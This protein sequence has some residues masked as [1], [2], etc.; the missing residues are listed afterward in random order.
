M[1]RLS[2]NWLS[3]RTLSAFTH[4][5][6][7]DLV[8]TSVAQRMQQALS[9]HAEIEAGLQ[10]GIPFDQYVINMP[11]AREG[12]N[13]VLVNT[14]KE[15][16]SALHMGWILMDMEEP[17]DD[18]NER[19]EK[20]SETLDH[21]RKHRSALVGSSEFLSGYYLSFFKERNSGNTL[22]VPSTSIVGRV[23]L[24]LFLTLV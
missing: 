6:K 10:S 7:T 20:I 19:F 17:L 15:L 13:Q 9:I 8:G 3:K 11:L 18:P 23:P 22:F 14:D 12:E 2:L 16:E 24:S 1:C 21:E 4:A 5:V